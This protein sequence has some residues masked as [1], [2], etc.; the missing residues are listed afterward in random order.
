MVI[1]SPVALR[2]IFILLEL[3]CKKTG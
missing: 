2:R 3:C 1:K